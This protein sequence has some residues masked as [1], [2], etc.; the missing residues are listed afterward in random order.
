M[1]PERDLWTITGGWSKCRNAKEAHGKTSLLSLE[2]LS[3]RSPMLWLLRNQDQKGQIP[4][5]CRSL[6]RKARDKTELEWATER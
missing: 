3:T 1:G 4:N 5:S 6:V 2:I